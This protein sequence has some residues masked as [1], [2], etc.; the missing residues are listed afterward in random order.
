MRAIAPHCINLLCNAEK[1]RTFLRGRGPLI[2]QKGPLETCYEICRISEEPSSDPVGWPGQGKPD[3]TAMRA[4]FEGYASGSACV[5]SRFRP[6]GLIDRRSVPEPKF[7]SWRNSRA[8]P[9]GEQAGRGNR[10]A[11]GSDIEEVR[12]R[13]LRRTKFVELRRDL[14]R[15]RDV[16]R[17]V[18]R[19]DPHQDGLLA[20]RLG[21]LDC[22]RHV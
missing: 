17:A 12:T 9:H 16:M 2:S 1:A 21:G 4:Q 7:E 3:G 10:P 15:Q 22:G 19:L 6:I 14:G 13:P 8:I 18:L 5:A 20:V 11:A